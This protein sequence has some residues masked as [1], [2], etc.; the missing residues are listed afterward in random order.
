M[1]VCKA[2]ER[3]GQGYP[4]L[5]NCGRFHCTKFSSDQE[6]KMSLKAEWSLKREPGHDDAERKSIE[7]MK[8]WLNT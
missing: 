5:Q 4:G 1:L 2:E 7:N 6:D 3:N 8:C